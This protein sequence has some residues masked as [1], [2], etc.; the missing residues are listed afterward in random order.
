MKVAFHSYQLGDR[1]TEICLYKYAKYNQEVLGNESIIIS[2][3]TRP[4][5]TLDLFQAAFD[6]TLYPHVWSNQRQNHDLK[7]YLENLCS[8]KGVDAFYAIKGGEDDDFMPENCKR[9]A[10]CIFRMD[11]PHGDVY[12]GV[13]D[14]ISNKFGGAHPAVHHILENESPEMEENYRKESGIPKDALVLGRHGGEQQFSLPFVHDAIA[15]VLEKRE[16]LWFVFLNTNPF[17]QHP[18]VKYFPWT[19]DFN[20]KGKFINTC[21]AM[22][23]ARQDGEIFS[24]S[25]A[26]FSARD[27]AIITWKPDVPPP[28][29]D[30]GHIYSL[31]NGALYY[32]DGQTLIDLLLNLNKKEINNTEWG[33]YWKKYT[34][35]HV[36]KE[37]KEVFLDD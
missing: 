26:E 34:P 14:Y 30:T 25:T 5:P 22:I 20:L 8:A 2:T 11:E 27:K 12:A 35:K 24:L 32:K 19:S 16:D 15:N 10:H 13:C 21:D 28:T 3:S 18:R 29:Y 6:T 17:I 36:M 37:F 31:G 1:G 7:K 23:H 4:T 33:D 9:L